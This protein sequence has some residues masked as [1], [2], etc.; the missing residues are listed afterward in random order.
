MADLVPRATTQTTPPAEQV[1]AP[2]SFNSFKDAFASKFE[3]L[4]PSIDEDSLI[5]SIEHA[6]SRAS[7]LEDNETED[8]LRAYR[9]AHAF[10]QQIAGEYDEFQKWKASQKPDETISKEVDKAVAEFQRKYN[11]VKVDPN[12]MPMLERDERTG[13]WR[14]KLPE[15]APRAE[16]ANRMMM[17]RQQLA[18]EM[19]SDPYAFG[20]EIARPIVDQYKAEILKQIEELKSQLAPIQQTAQEQALSQFEWQHKD[21]LFVEKDGKTE[22][23][24]AGMAYEKACKTGMNPKDAMEFAKEMAKLVAPPVETKV[25]DPKE[26]AKDVKKAFVAKAKQVDKKTGQPSDVSNTIRTAIET[27]SPQNTARMT[28]RARWRAAAA[29]AEAEILEGS[30][31]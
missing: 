28:P 25:V 17:Y 20:A 8:T 26:V 9:E 21:V 29:E 5:Q 27:K 18:E 15:L 6:T 11:P 12:I 13:M 4:D 2:T 3:G 16:E 30:A 7:L 10:K 22:L 24:P 23:S 14:A 1:T 19:Y 31:S